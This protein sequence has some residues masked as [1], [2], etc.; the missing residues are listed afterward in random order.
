MKKIAVKYI[1]FPVL[2]FLF[3]AGICGLWYILAI[4]KPYKDIALY[5]DAETLFNDYEF[6][7]EK[8]N[9]KYLFNYL[10]VN[11]TIE[12][13]SH[14]KNDQI[15]LVLNGG[16]RFKGIECTIVHARKQLK[17]PLKLGSKITI[18]GFCFGKKENVLMAGCFII[19]KKMN[20]AVW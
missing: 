3:F 1:F 20:L 9:D 18:Q 12:E 14:K 17:S 13:V 10:E 8:W 19:N 11:G 16:V 15:K 6:N 2:A 7:V 5:L 4:N